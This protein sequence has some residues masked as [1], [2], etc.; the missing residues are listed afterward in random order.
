MFSESEFS[1]T[2]VKHKAFE[3]N[4]RT[5]NTSVFL[6]SRF[7]PAD[8]ASILRKVEKKRGKDC[9]RVC[10]FF[11]GAV[12]ETQKE[13]KDMP[14]GHLNL[15]LELDETDHKH[16]ANIEGWAPENKALTKF[17][18]QSLAAKARLV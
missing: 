15:R 10:E 7:K 13:V 14:G 9:K 5:N 3:P 4:K 6:Y 12:L 1:S 18:C 17:I 8:F 2:Q 11:A 16:H